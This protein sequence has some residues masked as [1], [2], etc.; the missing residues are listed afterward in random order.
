ML[1]RWAGSKIVVTE[2][3]QMPTLGWPKQRRADL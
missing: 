1:Q 3:L 2:E